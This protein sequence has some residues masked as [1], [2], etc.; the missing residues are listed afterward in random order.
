MLS[1]NETVC[2]R[3]RSGHAGAAFRSEVEYVRG[4]LVNN[5]AFEFKDKTQ[6]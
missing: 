5:C 6:T 2:Q 3:Q 1:D 4:S